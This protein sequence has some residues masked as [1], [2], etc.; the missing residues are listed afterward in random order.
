MSTQFSALVPLSFLVGM[1]LRDLKPW[2][3]GRPPRLPRPARL[4]SPATSCIQGLWVVVTDEHSCAQSSASRLV[5]PRRGELFVLVNP[6]HLHTPHPQCLSVTLARPT[7]EIQVLTQV[8]LCF[9]VAPEQLT[10]DRVDAEAS[11][12]NACAGGATGKY[13]SPKKVMGKRKE[14][15]MK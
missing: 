2:C 5:S 11:F 14:R 6:P 4:H 12:C 9:L 8:F 13:V 15:V 3:L 1:V 10:K 7:I